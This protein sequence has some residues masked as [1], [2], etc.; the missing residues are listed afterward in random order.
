MPRRANHG[1]LV[2]TECRGGPRAV[3]KL[4][5]R[6]LAALDRVTAKR[7]RTVI[8]H[9]LKHGHI[10]TEELRDVYGYDHPPRAARD[11]REQGIP[12]E[13]FSLRGAHGRTIAA[14]RFGDL[15]KIDR[16]KLGG[17]RVFPKLLKSSLYAKQDG[18]CAICFQGYEGRYLQVDHRVPYEV[19]G[20][21][22]SDQS[23]VAGFLLIC[24]SCQ[25]G[26]SW[27]CEQCEN[28]RSIK[29]QKTC[30]TCYWGSPE[31]YT[32]LAMIALRREVLTWTGEDV[33]KHTRLLK[34]ALRAG[35]RLPDYIKAVLNEE[36]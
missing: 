18:R 30:A 23:D 29:E 13:T 31:E 5:Q 20:D 10:T 32:H 15:S 33:R 11:V 7:A 36:G 16:H 12:L 3:A 19:A 24:A 25:R 2:A 17:R 21:N 4:P 1:S 27:T 6:F 8:D 14:Y 28:W 22:V 35:V 9:I 26:K 34:K